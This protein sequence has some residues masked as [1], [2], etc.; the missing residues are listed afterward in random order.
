MDRES[1]KDN[2][3]QVSLF[4]FVYFRINVEVFITL[5]KFLFLEM[6]HRTVMYTFE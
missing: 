2:S 3:T 1:F 5:K 6:G 4:K